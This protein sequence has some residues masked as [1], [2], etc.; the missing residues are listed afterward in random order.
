[1]FEL[2]LILKQ[3]HKSDRLF[4]STLERAINI[5][6]VYGLSSNVGSLGFINDFCAQQLMKKKKEYE[7]FTNDGH[8]TKMHGPIL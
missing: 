2:G 8:R 1:M 5:N 4:T 6:S 7:N 3:E